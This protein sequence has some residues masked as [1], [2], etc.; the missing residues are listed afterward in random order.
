[1]FVLFGSLSVLFGA[2]LVGYLIT[3]AQ[4]DVWRTASMPGLPRGLLLSTVL[5]AGL[6]ASMQRAVNSVRRNRPDALLQ[7]LRVALVFGL[8]FVFAQGLNWRSMHIELLTTEA[9]T[10]YAFTFFMLTGLHALHVVAGFLPLGIVLNKAARREY[11]SSSHE[12][13]VLCAQ[14][15]HYL[16]VVW[17]VLVSALY[18][19]T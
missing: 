8:A 1:M 3:R 6:S 5:I 16:G 18:I 15:W 10:L 19:A 13:V 2:S 9:R 17:L 11:S 12:G 7:S 4:N 14:Y